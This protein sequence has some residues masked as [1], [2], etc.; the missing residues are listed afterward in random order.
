MGLPGESE[1]TIRETIDWARKI[2]PHTIQVSLAA[3]YPGTFLYKQAIENG[4]L[5]AEHAEL[6]DDQGVQIAPLHYPNLSHER[7]FENVETFY[8]A[9]YFRPKKIA[10]IVGEMLT[11]PDMMKRRLREGVEFREFLKDR[12]GAG[13]TVDA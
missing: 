8:K 10:S 4:W 6:V 7:I 11:N 2:N 13:A 1:E 12:K 3:P 5:D 9:F